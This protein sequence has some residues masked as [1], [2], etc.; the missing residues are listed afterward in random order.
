MEELPE[1]V[2]QGGSRISF[3]VVQWGKPKPTVTPLSLKQFLRIFSKFEVLYPQL[4]PHLDF[5]SFVNLIFSFTL[6]SSIPPSPT[7]LCYPAIKI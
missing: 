6:H 7:L 2:F 3:T 4:V 5:F 1:A